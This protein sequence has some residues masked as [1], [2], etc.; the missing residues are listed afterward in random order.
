MIRNKKKKYDR[1]RYRCEN[2]IYDGIEE[3]ESTKNQEKIDNS[4]PAIK[5]EPRIVKPEYSLR[6]FSYTLFKN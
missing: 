3:Y 4:K 5:I 6:S 2:D 1:N